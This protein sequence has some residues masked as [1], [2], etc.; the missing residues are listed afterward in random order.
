[1]IKENFTKIRNINSIE[2][3]DFKLM[4]GFKNLGLHVLVIKIL[5]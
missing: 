2:V 4:N 3:E 5:L 1:M